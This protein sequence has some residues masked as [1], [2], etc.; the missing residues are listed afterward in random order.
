MSM[1]LHVLFFIEYPY[2]IQVSEH[3][4]KVVNQSI[5]Q[6]YKVRLFFQNTGSS[7]Y[8]LELFTDTALTV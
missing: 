2:D 1:C 3:T 8:H 6:N 5:K 7:H 4:L